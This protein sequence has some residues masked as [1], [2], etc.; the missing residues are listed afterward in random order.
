[1]RRQ[2]DPPH[3]VPRAVCPFVLRHRGLPLICV[4]LTCLCVATTHADAPKENPAPGPAAAAS[5]NLLPNGDFD[6]PNDSEDGPAHWQAVDNLVYHWTVDPSASKRGKVLMIDTSVDQGHAVSW[7][8]QHYVH[9]APLE[10]APAKV[11]GSGY[12]HLGGEIGGFF[13]SDFIPV[14]E[15]GAYKILV[16][17]RGPGA[18]VFIRGY[19]KKV[20]LFFGDEHGLVQHHF[21]AARDEPN[22][23]KN[24]RPFKLI[25]R[26]RYTTWFPAGGSDEWQTY[27]HHQPR[28]PNS[29]EITE[30][31]RWIRIT[32]YPY[33]PPGRYWF[34]NI[35]VVEVDPDTKQAKP[36]AEEADLKEGKV[37]R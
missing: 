31:V 17:A 21:R 25:R 2:N 28:H 4:F 1:M 8:V 20:P 18:K 29:R 12:G 15:G 5:P 7:W 10:K 3:R 34:D 13:W 11:E 19:E 37:V 9:G 27:T 24:G 36:D 32:L 22:V 26:F 35:R 33:W 23:D 16:D 6:Q 14:K 30:D